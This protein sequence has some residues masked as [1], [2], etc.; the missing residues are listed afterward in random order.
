VGDTGGQVLLEPEIK[1]IIPIVK[2]VVR[3]KPS[4]AYIY[5]STGNI[6]L[7]KVN[8]NSKTKIRNLQA[9][10]FTLANIATIFSVIFFF[11]CM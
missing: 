8:Q 5:F 10:V 2:Y 1:D 3:H 9:S 7:C 4:L 6:F 11:V